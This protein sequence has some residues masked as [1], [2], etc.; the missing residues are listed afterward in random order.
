MTPD[1][2]QIQQQ[3]RRKEMTKGSSGTPWFCDTRQKFVWP[4]MTVP[5]REFRSFVATR[6]EEGR[7]GQKENK[8]CRQASIFSAKCSAADWGPAVQASPRA[9]ACA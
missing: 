5:E 2:P 9:R 1:M 7:K 6:L 4:E 3:G 8:S